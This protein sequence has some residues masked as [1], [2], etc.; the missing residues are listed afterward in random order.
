MEDSG[1]VTQFL[2]LPKWLVSPLN[3]SHSGVVDRVAW[4]VFCIN[5]ALDVAEMDVAKFIYQIDLQLLL[6]L[7]SLCLAQNAVTITHMPYSNSF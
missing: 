4:F 1:Q 7:I 5:N 3:P 6:W 2:L